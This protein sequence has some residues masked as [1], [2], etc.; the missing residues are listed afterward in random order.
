MADAHRRGEGAG[1]GASDDAA[2]G[3]TMETFNSHLCNA[4]VL[5]DHKIPL[6]IGTGFEGYVPKTRVLRHEAAMAMVNGLGFDR[7]LCGDHAG[8]GQASSA[9]TTA[10]AASSRARSPTWCCTTAIRSSTR[11]T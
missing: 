9:S 8:R 1:G 10:S 2:A 7:A 3:G 6:A 11:R 5:A 4:A